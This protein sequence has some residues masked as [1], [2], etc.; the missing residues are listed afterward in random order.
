MS[1]DLLRVLELKLM[2]PAVRGSRETTSALLADDFVE[3]GSNGQRYEKST[4]LDFLAADPG[5]DV[6]ERKVEDF[7]VR[8][9]ASSVA[10][11][12]YRSTTSGRQSLRSSL[13]QETDGRWRMLFHQGT[14]I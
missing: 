5:V 6:Q 9:V 10:L 1:A 2:D 13:W 12:T 4:I 11:V 14:S 8:M 7:S 3:F